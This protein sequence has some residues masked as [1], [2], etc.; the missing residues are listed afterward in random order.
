[1]L[2]LIAVLEVFGPKLSTMSRLLYRSIRNTVY[3]R[4]GFGFVVAVLAFFPGF[5]I[6][7]FWTEIKSLFQ[8]LL[9]MASE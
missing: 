9:R 5:V 1:M 6:G 2:A 4:P 7:F 8:L 3:T